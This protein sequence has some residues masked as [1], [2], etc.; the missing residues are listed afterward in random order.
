[1]RRSYRDGFTL[2][3]MLV[4]TALF[5]M[6][7]LIATNIFLLSSKAQRRAAQ[8]QKLQGDVRFAVE[9]MV[10]EVR[11]G[12]IDYGCYA[13]TTCD[14]EAPG[15]I[16][17]VASKGSSSVLA[18]RDADG[19]AVRFS[20]F[21]L[22]GEQK[23]VVCSINAT[24]EAATKCDMADA[25]QVITQ[26]GVRIVK[27]VFVIFPFKSPFELCDGSGPCAAGDYIYQYD[28]QPRVMI[29][30]KSRQTSTEALPEQL[31]TQT[32]VTSRFYAR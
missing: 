22:S 32:V 2:I 15:V 4:V 26:V 24:T 14:P 12:T 23:L 11:Y 20:V 29:T 21:T 25:W 9:S 7:M 27:V 8:N 19:N 5:A 3:E 18:L 10:R 1:M 6:T 28:E 16:D 30:V 31:Y 13:G 17:L